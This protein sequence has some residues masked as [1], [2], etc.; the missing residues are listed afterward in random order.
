MV[1]RIRSVFPLMPA[2]SYFGI[3]IVALVQAIRFKSDM[4]RTFHVV[5]AMLGSIRCGYCTI[6]AINFLPG[7]QGLWN[8]R[9][10]VWQIVLMQMPILLLLFMFSLVFFFW[11]QKMNEIK[12]KAISNQS[13]PSTKSSKMTYVLLTV[14][15]SI[16]CMLAVV[17]LFMTQFASARNFLLDTV[18]AIQGF[19]ALVWA[20]CFGW[21]SLRQIPGIFEKIHM[22]QDT[23]KHLKILRAVC[24]TCSMCFA[25]RALLLILEIWIVGLG[26]NVIASVVCVLRTNLF[27]THF[28][29]SRITPRAATTLSA[30]ACP[31]SACS[32]KPHP[33]L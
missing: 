15:L 19:F 30:S 10:R 8:Y 21:I 33:P 31:S 28:S 27:F 26:D 11:F 1:A 32:C 7:Y 4:R 5:A 18:H 12:A 6:L 22:T 25:S 2:R 14:N 16:A 29:C 20:F 24:M 9:Q 13:T 23:E 3:F 17:W